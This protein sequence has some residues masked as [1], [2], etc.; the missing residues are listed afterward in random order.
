MQVALLALAGLYAG[1]YLSAR[2]RIPNNRQTL[3]SVQVKT[4]YAVRQKNG[5]IEYSA[6]DIETQ[7]CVWSLFPHLGYVPCW[8]LSR[9]PTKRIELVRVDPS[10]FRV[11][12]FT[13]F[14][15]RE[16]YIRAD[17]GQNVVRSS[18][19]E[20]DSGSRGALQETAATNLD[21]RGVKLAF[22]ARPRLGHGRCPRD[23][24]VHV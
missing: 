1:D 8:Y 11:P 21:P 10:P 4:L 16:G 14:K 12:G 9:H 15:Y 22:A 2:Y 3:G 23:V 19:Q 6:G 7:S 13:F 17:V 20:A 24:P 18:R 5:R